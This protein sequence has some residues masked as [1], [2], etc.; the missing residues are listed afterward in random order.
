MCCC[1]Q[2]C[3]CGKTCNALCWFVSCVGSYYTICCSMMGFQLCKEAYEERQKRRQ[4]REEEYRHLNR[5]ESP[6]LQMINESDFVQHTLEIG[7][8]KSEPYIQRDSIT[9]KKIYVPRLKT[10]QEY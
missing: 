7:L 9:N 8:P 4:E 2:E 6:N 3:C 5:A 10:I 1:L